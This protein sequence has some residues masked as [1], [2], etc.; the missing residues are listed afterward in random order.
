MQRFRSIICLFLLTLSLSGLAQVRSYSIKGI[1]KDA[2]TGE[3]LTG[4]TLQLGNSKTNTQ[5]DGAFTFK[6][7]LPGTYRLTCHYVG[8]ADKDT[9]I[10][11]NSDMNLRLQAD[12]VS[13][14]LSHVTVNGRRNVETDAFARKTEKNA[15]GV[16]NV[17]SANAIQQSPDVTIANVLQRVSGV[18]LERG[19]NG[20]GRYAI[21]RG[22][23]QRYNYTLVNGIK[24]PSPDNKFRYVPMDIFPSDLVERV[25]LHKTLTPDME[26]DAIGGAVNMVMKNAPAN[27]LYLKASASAGL[28][29]NLLDNGYDKFDVSAVRKKSLYQ[30]YGPDYNATPGDFSRDN[31]NYTHTSAPVNSFATLAIGNRFLNKKLGVMLGASYQNVYKGY[32]SLYI[33]AESLGTDGTFI[34]KHVNVRKYSSHL[35]RTG[36]SLKL[37]Y[38]I[39]PNHTIS[40]YNLYVNLKEAQARQTNDTLATTPRTI[41]TGQVWYYGRSKYQD[42]TIYNSTLQGNH[43][44]NN[45][46]SLDWSAVYS[47]ATNNLPDYGEYEYDGGVYEDHSLRD[48]V[49][50]NFKR[51]WWHN[52]DRDLAGYLNL[53]YS[54]SLNN[55]PYTASIGG[56]YRDKKRETLYDS[57]TLTPVI[58]NSQAQLWN[59][60]Y[61]FNWN[62]QNPKG[63]FESA[64][65]YTSFEKIKAAYGMVKFKVNK[66]ETVA[67]VRMENTNQGYNTNLPV[68][69]E[70]KSATYNYTDIL[71]SVNFKYLLNSN[72]NLR[73]VYYSAVN[74][75]GFF[76]PVPYS[77]AGDDFDEHGNYNLQHATAQNVDV[78]YEVFTQSNGQFMIGGFYKHINNAIEYGFDFNGTQTQTAYRPGN[79]GNARNLGAEVV[80]EKYVGNFGIRANYTYTN[81]SISS[82]KRQPYLDENTAAK[83]RIVNEK[84]PLQGQSAHLA[85]AAILYKNTKSGTEFQFNWQ[86]TGKR[87]ALVSPYYGMDYWMKAMHVFDASAEQK[88]SKHIYLFAKVQNLFNN[89]Y[90]VYINKQPTNIA[91]IPFQNIASGKTLSQSTQTGRTYQLGIRFDLNK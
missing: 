71:P 34:M 10:T 90:E 82:P 53:H 30:Q 26:G 91:V 80:V 27:G 3:I 29:Q 57:Y 65:N 74:R 13:A 58:V 61:N 77:I 52:S 56:L 31:Y 88:M 72:A 25:E 46:L 39:N 68:T 24:I 83:S 5:L 85:N 22:M 36:G 49:I 21:I 79:Y 87:I 38:S 41:G 40:L 76:E 60:I 2:V 62:V 23:D 78:R 63:S 7:V 44:F 37:D 11:V 84:R 35:T 20:E 47:K 8:Y 59:G 1:I 55:I 66:L 18:S 69:V 33:P 45:G 48:N 12:N 9:T 17:V 86:L 81:S 51:D 15:V 64:N 42:Q 89:K 32:N 19:T 14:T 16:M 73:L 67:G 54:S 43:K 6:N 50:M 28:S 4:A 75:P 70:G